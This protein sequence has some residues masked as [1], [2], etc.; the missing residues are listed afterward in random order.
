MMR[1]RSSLEISTCNKEW[2][3]NEQKAITCSNSA[4]LCLGEWII[5]KRLW[6]VSQHEASVFLLALLVVFSLGKLLR[7]I[8]HEWWWRLEFYSDWEALYGLFILK[9][10]KSLKIALSKK[11]FVHFLS[12][13]LSLDLPNATNP[14]WLPSGFRDTNL[15]SLNGGGW[16]CVLTKYTSILTQPVP[17]LGI[18]I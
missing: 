2:I 8:I 10:K 1:A 17:L 6:L 18:L 4:T 9:K 15:T 3:V 16:G 13:Y 14:F 12:I 7:D 11:Q 5:R